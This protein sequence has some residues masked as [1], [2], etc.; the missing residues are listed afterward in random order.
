M[1]G[2]SMLHSIL[3]SLAHQVFL[4]NLIRCRMFK[5]ESFEKSGCITLGRSAEQSKC[6]PLRCWRRGLEGVRAHV[7]LGYGLAPLISSNKFH[8]V[9]T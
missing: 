5:R 7:R 4:V 3:R 1:V 8:S 9:T 2:V 6:K